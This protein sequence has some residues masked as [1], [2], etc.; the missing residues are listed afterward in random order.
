MIE[1]IYYMIVTV[2]FT[3]FTLFCLGCVTKD[4]TWNKEYAD[5]YSATAHSWCHDTG[6]K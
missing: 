3:V 4:Q 6:R 5:C 1:V 2:L